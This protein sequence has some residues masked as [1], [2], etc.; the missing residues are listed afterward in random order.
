MLEVRGQQRKL[1][2]T[3]Y[4]PGILYECQNKGVAKFAFC[5]WMRTREIVGQ[6]ASSDGRE[7]KEQ[8][9]IGFVIHKK[10]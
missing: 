2:C 4:T 3:P 1:K 10:E 9:R 8:A 6:G 7:R 5:N